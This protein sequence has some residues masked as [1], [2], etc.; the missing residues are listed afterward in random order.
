MEVNYFQSF[1]DLCHISFSTCLKTDMRYAN[2]NVKNEY[3]RYRRLKGQ[4]LSEDL[5]QSGL[6]IFLSS[7]LFWN[8]LNTYIPVNTKHLYNIYTM[9]DQRRRRCVDVV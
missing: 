3:T 2:K 4:G 1:A 5:P 8:L 6:S 9:L 7:Y